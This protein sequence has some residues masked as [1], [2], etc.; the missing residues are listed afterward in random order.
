MNA[1]GTPRTGWSAF[2]S[3][4]VWFALPILLSLMMLP[5]TGQAA[6]PGTNG[7]IAFASNR[8]GNYEIYVMNADGSGVTRLTNISATD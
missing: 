6:F 1:K 2:V 7:L 8:D 3:Q 5:A 4:L